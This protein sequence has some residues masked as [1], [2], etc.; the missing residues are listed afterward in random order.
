MK[1]EICSW[2]FFIMSFSPYLCWVRLGRNWALSGTSAS[3]AITYSTISFFVKASPLSIS[4][5]SFIFL[6]G[7]LSI[8]S[9]MY[10]AAS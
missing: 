9:D 4:V 7:P 2:L 1:Y 3:A 5:F 10:L 6:V 8:I